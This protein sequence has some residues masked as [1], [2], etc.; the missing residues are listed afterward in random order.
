MKVFFYTEAGRRFG[1]GHLFRC[2]S[3]AQALSG[4]GGRPRFFIQGDPEAA[5]LVPSS[6]FEGVVSWWDSCRQHRERLMAEGAC[7]V[8]I[9]SYHA[10]PCWYDWAPHSV[11]FDDEN[12]LPYGRGL[13]L[14]A[15]LYAGR[16]PYP[17][18]GAK[19]EH[20]FGP[21]WQMLRQSF[22]NPVGAVHQGPVHNLFLSLG[23]GDPHGLIPEL[24]EMARR[25]LP[26]VTLQVVTGSKNPSLHEVR[27]RLREGDSCH[28]DLDDKG[29]AA[30]MSGCQAG[31]AAA[32]Q[33]LFEA[34]SLGLP[35]VTLAIAENQQQN[36]AS[37]G[38]AGVHLHAGNW[39]D[40]DWQERVV[41]LLARLDDPGVRQ[42]LAQVGQRLVDGQGPC[43]L[44]GRMMAVQV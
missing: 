18:P 26:G 40:R 7:W 35:L 24:M 5:R 44:A 3:L 25:I 42:G 27:K 37:F 41:Q 31:L 10:P 13:V 12:R 36:G 20:L 33:T 23:G 1:Y 43:R 32:G 30:V 15:S 19:R 2:L 29:M 4:R 22:W 39:S 17:E 11:V 6:W 8:V 28:C 16:L 34:A 9:D 14:N 21:S 38:Q